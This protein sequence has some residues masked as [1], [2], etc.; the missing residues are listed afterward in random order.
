MILLRNNDFDEIIDSS[1]PGDRRYYLLPCPIV[2]WI[3]IGL[4]NSIIDYL[5]KANSQCDLET[6][7]VR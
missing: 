5:V 2:G 3:I 7:D 6:F 4:I 1:L